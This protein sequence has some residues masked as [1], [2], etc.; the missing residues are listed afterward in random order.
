MSNSY[1]LLLVFNSITIAN[2]YC[3]PGVTL[4]HDAIATGSDDTVRALVQ[5]NAN[6]QAVNSHNDDAI[7]AAIKAGRDKVLDIIINER[8]EL[9]HTNHVCTIILTLLAICSMLVS[10]LSLRF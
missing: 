8:G 1:R 6:I 2:C 3:P 9:R 5:K 7:E 10:G 4:L